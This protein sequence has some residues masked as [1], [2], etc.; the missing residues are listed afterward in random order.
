MRISCVALALNTENELA[1][2]PVSPH[3]VS[4]LL[5]R[6]GLARLCVFI[7]S[8]DSALTIKSL[9]RKQTALFVFYNTEGNMLYENPPLFFRVHLI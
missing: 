9:S 6:W 5:A 3:S 4:G 8:L 1:P 7:C 2:D